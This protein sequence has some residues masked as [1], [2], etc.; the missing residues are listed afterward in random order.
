MKKMGLAVILVMMVMLVGGGLVFSQSADISSGSAGG[1]QLQQ[2]AQGPRVYFP[3]P[4]W[5]FG[6]IKQG[7]KVSHT[8][9]L[10][11]SGT[12][13]LVIEQI[14]PSCGCTAVNPTQNVLKPGET[15]M[16][17]TTF[18]SAGR[19]GQQLKKV[20]VITNDPTRDTYELE[21]KGTIDIP[22]GPRIVYE[23]TS[24]DFGLQEQGSTP[25]KDI[26]I[27][28]EGIG[29]LE[30][31]QIQTSYQCTA[32]LSPNEPIPA[33]GQAILTISLLPLDKPGVV[34]TYVNI[35]T[36]DTTRPNIPVRILGYV[37][38]KLPPSVLLSPTQ[39]DFG[40]VYKDAFK[41]VETV[42][43]L[44]NTGG[45]NLEVQRLKIPY[46]FETPVQTPFTVAPG[47]EANII[48]R[49]VNPFQIGT[50]QQYMFLY[51]NDPTHG[52][53]RINVYGYIAPSAQDQEQP[54]E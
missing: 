47:K 15:A 46:G 17:E 22:P 25:S 44:R 7:Q 38:G 27:K 48:L 11:N 5:D 52:A 3:E 40:I 36:N 20:Y 39:W 26:V 49:L 1:Q 35:R 54:I 8:F 23:P 30:L 9:K 45:E 29:N 13:D 12:S 33:G 4:V 19:D 51:T 16:L 6:V 10:I 41:P 50:V 53:R 28:N 21:I 32:S 24:W 37:K 18:D 34:E 43:Y 14:R 31:T 2:A 42:F